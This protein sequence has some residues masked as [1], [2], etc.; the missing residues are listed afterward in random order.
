MWWPRFTPEAP[1][2]PS[3]RLVRS[4]G[5][6]S[7]VAAAL[8]VAIGASVLVGWAANVWWLRDPVGGFVPMVPNTA[9]LLILAG[10]SLWLCGRPP[11]APARRWIARALALACVLGELALLAQDA[12]GLDFGIDTL[13]FDTAPARPAV[14]SSVAVLLSGLAILV[15]DVRPK[16]GPAPAELLAVGSWALGSLALGGYIYGDIQFFAAPT[17][18]RSASGLAIHTSLAVLALALGIVTAR[19]K[20]GAMATLTSSLVGGHV[21][22]RVFLIVNAIPVIGFL[23]VC[24]QKAGMYVPPGSVVVTAVGGTLLAILVAFVVSAS[25]NRSDL[26]RLRREDENREWRRFFDR[27]SF[28]AVLGM[29]NGRIGRVNEAFAGMHGYR[30]EEIVGRLGVDFFPANRRAEFAEKLRIIYER[31]WCRWESENVRKDGTVF[32]V[33]IDA[34]AVRDE[35]GALLYRAVYL[36]DITVEKEDR[37]ARSRLASIVESADDAITAEAPDGTVLAWNQGAERV[38]GYA[39]A[40]MLGQSMRVVVPDD[41]RAE[42][43]ARCASVLKREAVVSAEME[44]V[45]KDGLRIPIALTMSPISD[46][47]GSVDAISTIAH[48]IRARRQSERERQEWSAVVA[49]DLRQ[50]A[51]TIRLATEVVAR[52]EGPAKEKAIERV[53]RATGRLDRMIGDLLDVSRVESRRLAVNP[54]T[55][56]LG[57]LVS[58]VVEVTPEV[59]GRCQTRVDPQASAAW[60]DPERIVQ[61][62][63]NLLSNAAKY[64]DP[65]APIEIR[66]DRGAGMVLVTVTNEGPGI[67]PEEVPMLFSRFSRTTSAISGGDPGLGLGLY[68]SRGVVEALGGELWVESVPGA[69]THFRFTLPR[70]KSTV[71]LG[72]GCHRRH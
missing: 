59:K 4:L 55:V 30:A 49:H 17:G 57:A 7:Y 2:Q 64:G 16:R 33:R 52:M 44:C 21:L 68:I 27:A 58:E 69:K 71:P 62:L 12:L 18:H 45:R 51:A 46:S 31:G 6:V 61:V 25:L 40:E 48:D 29:P 41:L 36:Q 9:L 37:A 1:D 5:V 56:N 32:P 66:V 14:A 3:P 47:V 28:G 60:A 67:A 20:S 15:I 26:M 72:E 10:V 35:R 34:T 24:A 39:T 63:S 19:P 70:E 50:P 8:V 38:Y 43:E 11:A 54:K 65:D 22:R 23:A 42:H 53:R 13:L